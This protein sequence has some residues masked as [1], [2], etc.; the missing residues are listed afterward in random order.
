MHL[1]CADKHRSIGS[2]YHFNYPKNG[3]APRPENPFRPKSYGK[4]NS[5]SQALEVRLLDMDHF[6]T[7]FEILLLAMEDGYFVFP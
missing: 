5:I 2:L 7:S 4:A 1:S 6:G 3:T